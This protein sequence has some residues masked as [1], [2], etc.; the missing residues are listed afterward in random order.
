MTAS[1]ETSRPRLAIVC[2]TYWPETTST[3][4]LITELAEN[5]VPWFEVEVLTAQPK[6]NGSYESRA[7]TEEHNA[8]KIR[9]LWATRFEKSSRFGRL[10]N[11]FSFFAS[12]L[13]AVALR[14]GRRTYLFTTNPPVAPWAL[15]VARLLGQRTLVLVYDLYPDLAEAIGVVSKGGRIAKAFD[16]VNRFCFKRSHAIVVLGK[17]MR[18]RLAA[19]VEGAVPL[20]IIPN[21]A[22]GDLIRPQ[23]KSCSQFASANELQHRFVF[24]YAGNL[25][26]FQDLETLAAAIELVPST[27]QEPALVFVGDGGKRKKI[28]ELARCSRRI[29]VFDYLPYE[30]LGDL[31]ASSDIGLIALE[32]SVEKTNVPSKTYSIL[33]AGKPFLAVCDSSTDLLDLA[34]E[35]CGVCVPND[36]SLVAAA[37]TSYLEDT[38]SR[39]TMARRARSVFDSR[40]SRQAAVQRYVQVLQSVERS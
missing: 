38:T 7:G 40:F 15:L 39:E 30:S 28:E 13:I 14:R 27:G 20:H 1:A 8:V 2:E 32:P 12:V 21:W 16:F 11:W 24:L 25:G 35:G 33:A 5:L 29:F 36:A 4:Q 34:Q 6:Y 22:N 17:D 19:K 10:C 31:Y 18:E 26:L 37:M 23:P 3:S 9:R